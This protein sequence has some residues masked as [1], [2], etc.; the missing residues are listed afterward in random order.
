VKRLTVA[1]CDRYLAA[2]DLDGVLR[3]AGIDSK[4]VTKHAVQIDPGQIERARLAVQNER[5]KRQREGR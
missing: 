4:V 1:V 2:R 3:N 5:L